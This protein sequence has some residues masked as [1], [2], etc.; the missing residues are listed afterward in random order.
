MK[1][2]FLSNPI[3]PITTKYASIAVIKAKIILLI[4]TVS[5]IAKLPAN[6][7]LDRMNR[8]NAKSQFITLPDLL[9]YVQTK[10]SKLLHEQDNLK[11]K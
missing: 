7:E 2:I 11:K 3:L 5:A 4:F 6:I 9:K 8:H 10:L 1:L